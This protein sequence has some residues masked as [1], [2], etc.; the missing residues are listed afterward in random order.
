MLPALV[1]PAVGVAAVATVGGLI[2]N[3][4]AELSPRLAVSI[5]ILGYVLAR[6]AV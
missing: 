2:C 4:A 1:L 5:I 6:I 3:Y